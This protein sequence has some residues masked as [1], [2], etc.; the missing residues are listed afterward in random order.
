MMNDAEFI[1]VLENLLDSVNDTKREIETAIID[2]KSMALSKSRLGVDP[3]RQEEIV[4]SLSIGDF[5]SF[6]LEDCPLSEEELAE[7]KKRRESFD[8]TQGV[9]LCDVRLDDATLKEREAKRRE[10]DFSCEAAV[11]VEDKKLSTRELAERAEKRSGF[12]FS[13]MGSNNSNDEGESI[14]LTDSKLSP[15]QL[16]RRNEYRNR[17]DFCIGADSVELKD[18]K[19]SDDELERR[20]SSRAFDF[21]AEDTG[22]ELEDVKLS[23][24]ELSERA[25]KRKKFNFSA[26][27][28]VVLDDVKLSDEELKKRERS[29]RVIDFTQGVSVSD[30]KLTPEE[31]KAREAKRESMLDAIDPGIELK[32]VPLDA[33]ELANYYIRNKE[34]LREFEPA[35]DN[36]FYEVEVQRKILIESYKQLMIGTGMDLGIY[37][38]DK[39]IG[40]IKV[41]N[42]V[43]GV[44]KSAFIGYSIDKEHEGKGYMKEAVLLVEKYCKQYLD[45]H[46]LEAS[47]LVDNIKSKRVLLKSGFEE[48]GI[49][50]KYLYINGKWRDH[51][52]FYKILE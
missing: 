5:D 35:R 17:I 20:A 37:L 10:F 31:L 32:D 28:S 14:E 13:V 9:E 45:L 33:E 22:V 30:R 34:H 12:N 46:R 48:I 41:S 3:S 50:K 1:A 25:A 8:F 19:L 2:V 44:F 40:K 23:A 16:A 49:N 27:D 24:K 6:E 36:S 43:H 4:S 18:K 7:R 29:R 26:D 39:L 15:D 38:K 42:I 11:E 52:T 47:V 21:S 51:I